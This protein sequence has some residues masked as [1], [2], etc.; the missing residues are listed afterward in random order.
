M[1][2]YI[3]VNCDLGESFGN[4]KIG[5]D[6]LLM[7]HITSCNIACGFH[8]GD[9]YHIEQTI[10]NALSY[11]LN[12]GAHPG[13]PDLAG[14]GRRFIDLTPEVLS[15]SIKYQVGALQRLVDSKGGK[16]TYVKPHGALY[17]RIIQNEEDAMIVLKAVKSMGEDLKFMGMAGSRI[18]SLSADL[19]IE[20][21]NEGFADRLYQNSTKLLSR[22]IKNALI[23]NAEKSAQQVKELVLEGKIKDHQGSIVAIDVQSICIHGD[24][25]A[26]KT[27]LETIDEMM[28]NHDIQKRAF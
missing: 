21:I 25:P 1:T 22:K 24:N 17:H 16:L 26:A 13:Y 14:F 7:P 20:F 19:N 2:K 11:E 15:S 28:S 18:S 23:I 6:E 3:D 12:I 8:A 4:F 10:D 9:P 5:Q 27:I